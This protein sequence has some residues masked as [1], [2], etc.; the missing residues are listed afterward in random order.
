YARFRSGSLTKDDLIEIAA[1]NQCAAL[2]PTFA[3]LK[4]SEREFY[5]LAKSHY[6]RTWVADGA[7]IMLGYPLTH[8]EPGIPL[9]VDFNGQVNLLGADWQAAGDGSRDRYLSL[10][11]KMGGAPFA[12]NYKIFVQLRNAAGQTVVSADHE[13]FDGLLPTQAWRPNVILKDTTRVAIPAE[14]GPGTATLYVGLYNPASLER[15]PV[16]ADASGENAA[17]IPGVEIK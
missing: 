7:E 4:N 2:V 3:R 15:L 8:A 6:L 9:G 1:A 10:Y 12:E 14:L 13:M 5:D 16:V 11:W 17:V